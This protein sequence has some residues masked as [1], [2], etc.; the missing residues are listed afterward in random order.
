MLTSDPSETF[1]SVD[2]E[3]SGPLPGEY[4]LLSIGA[5]LADDP[6]QTFYIEVKPVNANFTPEALAV[7]GLTLENMA[8]VGVEPATALRAFAA[9]ISAHTPPGA[10]PIMVAFNAPFDWMFVNYYFL[11]YTGHNPFGHTALDIKAFALGRRGGTWARTS[12]RY[13][14]EIY[15]GGNRLT[16]NALDDALAQ[17]AL[18]RRIFA[19]AQPVREESQ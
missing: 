2:I 12:M 11:K 16:H 5:C 19:E 14:A 13:L 9:W 7:H 15:L 8:S 18:F 6:S 4:S 1:I 3:S 17:A 10:R